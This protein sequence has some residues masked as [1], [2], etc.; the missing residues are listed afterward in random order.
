[1]IKAF[2]I[3]LLLW[4]ITAS[5]ALCLPINTDT[6]TKAARKDAKRFKL[7]DA[8]WK[9]SR[10]YKFPPSSDHFKPGEADVSDVKFLRDSA[11]VT[12]FRQYAYKQNKHRHTTWHYLLVGGEIAAG[13][14]AAALIAIIIFIAPHEG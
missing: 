7:D 5:Q 8:T 11:Y 10:K 13:I 14:A 6:V 1:M 4:T 12:A 3:C 9:L 2:C